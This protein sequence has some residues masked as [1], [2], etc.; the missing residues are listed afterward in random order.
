M[1][2]EKLS[3]KPMTATQINAIQGEA[4]GLMRELNEYAQKHY[5]SQPGCTCD[6]VYI[7][8]RLYSAL[9]KR[10]GSLDARAVATPPC[11]PECGKPSCDEHE[12]WL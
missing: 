7:C 9:I 4:L 12:Y 1:P 5:R 6:L 11:C 8:N 2:D 10:L 3:S